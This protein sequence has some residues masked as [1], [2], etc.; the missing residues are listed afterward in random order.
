MRYT[1][2]IEY[3]SLRASF[4]TK[5]YYTNDYQKDVV[6]RIARYHKGEVNSASFQSETSI[7]L[8]PKTELKNAVFTINKLD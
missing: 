3:R 6:N 4:T 7:L 8:L 2:T 5:E 1:I